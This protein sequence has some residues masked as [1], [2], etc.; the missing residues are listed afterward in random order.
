MKSALLITATL[1]LLTLAAV[2]VLSFRRRT[3]AHLTGAITGKLRS[4][5]LGVTAPDAG[6]MVPDTPFGI[7]GVVAD[8]GL[9]NGTATV[10]ALRDGTASLYLSS[11]GGIIGGES[12]EGVRQAVAALLSAAED[13]GSQFAPSSPQALPR[14]GHVR[15]YVHGR[16]GLLA[17]PEIADTQLTSGSAPLS[18]LFLTVNALITQFR[19]IPGAGA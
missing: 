17:S 10:V 18:P 2:G 1:L 3:D 19:A 4:M 14:T 16:A 12:H 6:I 5:A 13:A 15:F 9:S 11:G 8:V 7:W